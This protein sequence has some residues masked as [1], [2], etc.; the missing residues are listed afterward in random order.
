MQ[1]DKQRHRIS[2]QFIEEVEE[3]NEGIHKEWS[4]HSDVEDDES[5]Q[6]IIMNQIII[7]NQIMASIINRTLFVA[8]S[9]LQKSVRTRKK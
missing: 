5:K 2:E 8:F 1:E 7:L 3:E 4:K 9:C 6:E